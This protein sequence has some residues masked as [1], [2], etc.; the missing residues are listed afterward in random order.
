MIGHLRVLPVATRD[1]VAVPW[2]V[3]G[4]LAEFPMPAGSTRATPGRAH[5][6]PY[7]KYS[8]TKLCSPSAQPTI[9]VQPRYNTYLYSRNSPNRVHSPVRVGQHNLYLHSLHQLALLKELVRSN[10]CFW[11][12]IGKSGDC[13]WCA[14]YE[15]GDK[16]V[17]ATWKGSKGCRGLGGG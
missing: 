4:H 15:S 5:A 2:V 8:L 11:C 12:D 16:Y 6:G 13:S 7:P 14:A 10:V 9:C 1:P 17:G 3:P